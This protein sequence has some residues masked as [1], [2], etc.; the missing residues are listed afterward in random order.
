DH[1]TALVGYRE[2]PHVDMV[3]TGLRAARV[4][5][6]HLRGEIRP[7]VVMRKVPLVLPSIF[8][9]TGLAPLRDIQAQARRMGEVAARLLDISIFTGFAYSDVPMLGC[10]VVAVSDGD[11]AVAEA[12]VAT[13]ADRIW[14]E[15][16]AI[17]RRDLLRSVD[18]AVARVRTAPRAGKPIVL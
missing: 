15:R 7:V 5:F 16:H 8:T 17:Y 2:S 1:L 9:A 12:A 4:L 6:G 11:R 10:T 14:S 18:E 13:L 3:E